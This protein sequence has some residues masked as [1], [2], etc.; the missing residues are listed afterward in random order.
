MVRP[1]KPYVLERT[2]AVDPLTSPMDPVAT[3][4]QLCPGQQTQNLNDQI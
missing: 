1:Q 3:R 4:L 2:T